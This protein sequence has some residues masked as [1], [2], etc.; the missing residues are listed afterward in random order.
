MSWKPEPIGKPLGWGGL[1]RILNQE[2]KIGEQMSVLNTD[3]P[4]NGHVDAVLYQKFS[5]G[6]VYPVD[7]VHLD[8]KTL[9]EK[10]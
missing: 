4:H 2:L 6:K 5:D 1:G 10:K 8:P 9:N 3:N 7:K